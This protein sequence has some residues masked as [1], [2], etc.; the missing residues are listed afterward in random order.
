MSIRMGTLKEFNAGSYTATVQMTASYKVY[1][2]GVNVAQNIAAAEMLSGRRV[3]VAF[4]DDH[5]VK[6]AVVVAVFAG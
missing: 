3:A 4:F 6:E 1:L 5:N 2:E